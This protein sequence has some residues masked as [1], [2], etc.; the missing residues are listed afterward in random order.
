VDRS[1]YDPHVTDVTLRPA[2]A[3]DTGAIRAVA[4]ASWHA[5]Y[6]P[7]LGADRVDDVVDSWYDPERLV[8]DDV[9]P[10]ERPLFVADDG[11]TVVGFAEAVP[12]DEDDDTAHLYRIYVHPDAWG[13]GIGGSLLDRIE[14]VLRERGFEWLTLSVMAENDVGVR[15]YE[16]KGFDRTATTRNERLGIREYEYGKPL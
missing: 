15:F 1:G 14:R 7:V 16:S 8:T 12:D 3:S 10:D 6:D 13:G 5:A 2:T 11:G 9:E 4:R